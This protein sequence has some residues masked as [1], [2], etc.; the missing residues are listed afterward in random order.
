MTSRNCAYMAGRKR[1]GQKRAGGRTFQE[2]GGRQECTRHADLM[3]AAK[4][5]PALNS[6][7]Y[8]H[9]D[10]MSTR[11]SR[12]ELCLINLGVSS[13]SPGLLRGRDLIERDILRSSFS[14]ERTYRTKLFCREFSKLARPAAFVPSMA[15]LEAEEAATN[16]NCV[17]AYGDQ[18]PP[19]S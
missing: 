8:E 13:Y 17:R 19:I 18:V 10:P 16:F 3:L 12:I 1:S 5:R 15:G 14:G 4:A 2:G 7:F 9:S 11:I 6:F